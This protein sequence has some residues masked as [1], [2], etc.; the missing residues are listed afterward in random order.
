MYRFPP[1]DPRYAILF[2][3]TQPRP[4][5]AAGEVRIRGNE[6]KFH[7]FLKLIDRFDFRF[8]IATP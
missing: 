8:N 3:P 7:D 5:K 6:E 4:K 1:P 2:L